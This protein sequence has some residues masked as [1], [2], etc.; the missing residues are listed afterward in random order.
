MPLPQQQ[1][2][3]RRGVLSRQFMSK[4]LYRHIFAIKETPNGTFSAK[5]VK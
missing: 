5:A 4:I 2:T 3:L 1:P